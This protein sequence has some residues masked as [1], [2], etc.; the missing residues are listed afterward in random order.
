MVSCPTTEAAWL[1]IANRFGERW[2]FQHT[3]GDVDGKHVVIRRPHNCG[4]LYYNCK[5]CHSII[6]PALVNGDYKFIWADIRVND[7]ASDAQ[8][9]TNYEL[10]DAI[11][12]GVIGFPDHD[13]LSG[14]D[15]DMPYFIIGDNAFPLRTWIMK[16]IGRQNMPEP[17]RI[18]N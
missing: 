10:R 4:S 17:E 3:V 11:D 1:R 8:V 14:D 2:Q 12:D 6:L 9:F 18:F 7:S 15:E 13:P 16:L 5:D